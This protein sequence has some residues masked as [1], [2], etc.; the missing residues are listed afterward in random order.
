MSVNSLE[1]VSWGT[2]GIGVSATNRIHYFASWGITSAVG[3]I[4]TAFFRRT[5]GPRIGTRQ[6]IG[7]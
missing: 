5:F 7:L 2:Y 3:G 1:Y 6:A 4:V